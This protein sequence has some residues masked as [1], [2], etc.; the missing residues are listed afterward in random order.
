[1]ADKIPLVTIAIPTYNRA[2]GYLKAALGS[3]VG[4][5]YPNLEI[6]VSD[7]CSS[8]DTALVVSG[9]KDPRIRYFRQEKNIGA[10]NNFNFCL[11]RANGKY[12]LLLQDDDLIDADFI[13]TCMNEV[14]PAEVGI[15]RTGTR[16]IDARGRLIYERKN[17]VRGLAMED[18]FAGWFSGK[19]SL[20]L[21]STLFNTGLLKETGGFG[22]KHNLFQ[23]VVAEVR[24]ASLSGR[25]DIPEVKASFRRHGSEMTFSVRVVNWCE[26]SLLLLDQMCEAVPGGAK[27]RTRREGMRFFSRINYGR[28]GAVKSLSG[29]YFA[30]YTVW[31]KFGFRYLPPVKNLISPAFDILR[32]GRIYSALRSMK[33]GLH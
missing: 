3:A 21:C 27:E 9:F 30:Y 33:N 14:G 32:G 2:D 23:D 26:D 22:S 29:R 18:F 8:D 17:M 28:A 20:Y 12:F 31:K 10:N 25:L 19:T 13:E 4:Q 5:T 11:G 7:N 24:L 16:I 15:I 1:M 6:I